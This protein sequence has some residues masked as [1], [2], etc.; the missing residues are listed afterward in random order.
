[1]EWDIFSRGGKSMRHKICE[2]MVL[3]LVL[4][5]GGIAVLFC[6]PLFGVS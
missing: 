5:V 3:T 2:T 6:L 1:M 4:A